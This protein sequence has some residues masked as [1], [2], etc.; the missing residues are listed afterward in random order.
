[1]KNITVS[2]DEETYRRARIVAAERDTSVSGLVKEFLNGI[3]SKEARFE[4]L[5]QKERALRESITDFDAQD[6]LSRDELH[7]R[8][9]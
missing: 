9:R 8:R 4:R 7:E 5:L 3:E 2:V 1:M 6:R